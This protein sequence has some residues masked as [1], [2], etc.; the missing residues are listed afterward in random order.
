MSCEAREESELYSN[1]QAQRDSSFQ[2]K[3]TP[4]ELLWT[5]GQGSKPTNRTGTP[6]PNPQGHV[7]RMRTSVE[8]TQKQPL[9]SDLRGDCSEKNEASVRIAVDNDK[10]RHQS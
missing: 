7:H 3:S 4:E 10:T 5:H 8:R 6:S 2:S 9:S 1:T